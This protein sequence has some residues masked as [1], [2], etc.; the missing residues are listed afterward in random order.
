MIK[1]FFKIVGLF[2]VLSA[3]C[4]PSLSSANVYRWVDKEGGVHFSDQPRSGSEKVDV[5]PIPT[6]SAPPQ[7]KINKPSE[8]TEKNKTT[9]FYSSLTIVSP[10]NKA[11]VRHN[12][13]NFSVRIAL[14]PALQ[15]ADKIQFTIDG[16]EFPYAGKTDDSFLLENV[17][18]GEH[19]LVA[20]VIDADN[21]VLI[22][23]PAIIFYM[24]QQSIAAT[25]RHT[26]STG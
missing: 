11:T 1:I 14:A 17:H 16:K 9:A 4:L 3:L 25:A 21:K 15:K 7:E 26:T 20:Q 23:S 19:T 5:P 22:S 12:S 6:Y 13:G 24:H 10:T 2:F 18:R 8:E